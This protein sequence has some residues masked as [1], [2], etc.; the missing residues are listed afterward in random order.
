M[1]IQLGLGFGKGRR[2]ITR[3]FALPTGAYSETLTRA[4]AKHQRWVDRRA[5]ATGAPEC[6]LRGD[7]VAH[8][9]QI[10]R[11]RDQYVSSSSF[12]F[13]QAPHGQGHVA[14]TRSLMPWAPRHACPHLRCPH[15]LAPGQPCPDHPRPRRYPSAWAAYARAWLRRF[16]TCGM[17]QDGQLY[18]QHS[19]CVRRGA[20]VPAQVVDH[21]RSL[22]AGG[23]LFDPAN[24]QSLCRGCNVAKG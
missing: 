17:R 19:R 3:G 22:V 24:H 10:D 18:A 20:L 12:F 4:L 7:P 5:Q 1:P 16:P 21:I 6:G 15:L 11:P 9:R 2:V 8:V 14:R 23:S 13:S